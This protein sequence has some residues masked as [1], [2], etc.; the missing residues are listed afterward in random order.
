M[1]KTCGD[2][3][4]YREGARPGYG[5][6]CAKPPRVMLLDVLKRED[7]SLSPLTDSFY[8]PV[9]AVTRQC[10]DEFQQ[11]HEGDVVVEIAVAEGSA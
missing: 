6:C 3:T 10:R 8:P 9:R 11:R 5:A 4:G 2:C 7:G 1:N